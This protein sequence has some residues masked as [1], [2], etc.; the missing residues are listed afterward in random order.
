MKPG[1]FVQCDLSR[2]RVTSHE[3]RMTYN[4]WLFIFLNLALLFRNEKLM[5]GRD[6]QIDSFPL[7]PGSMIHRIRR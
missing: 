7:Q 6:R 5:S 3:L 1:S 4:T 2:G